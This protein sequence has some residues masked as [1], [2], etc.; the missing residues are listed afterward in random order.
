MDVRF[1]E[2]F[3]GL[4]LLVALPLTLVVAA[5]FGAMSGLRRWAAA[6]VR[7]AL[8]VAIVLL[9]VG[10][11]TVQKS[12]KVA[13]VAVV[14]LSSSVRRLGSA[15]SQRDYV[16]L[17]QQWLTQATAKRGAEDLVGV[18]AV[19]RTPFVI[20][21]VSGA[22]LASRDLDVEVAEG[23]NL[24]S[25]I[26]LARGMIP[27][28][29]VGRIVLLSDGNQTEGD[30]LAEVDALR[31]SGR[32][33]RG[34]IRLDVVPLRYQLDREVVVQ[35]IDAP[36][37]SA[38]ESVV[39][40]RVMLE[41]TAGA[42][43]QIVVQ[44]EGVLLDAN[45][46][47]PG[48]GAAAKLNPGT[49]IV[50]IQVKLPP[51]RVHRFQVTF[52]QDSAVAR[53]GAPAGDTLLENNSGEAFTLSPGKGQTLVLCGDLGPAVAP[54][55]SPLVQTL[56]RAG[57]EVRGMKPEEMPTDM[58]GVQAY[59]VVVLDNVPADRIPTEV[60]D[61]LVSFVTELGGGLVMVG[62]RD[63]FGA[64]GWRGTPIEPILPVSLELKDRLTEPDAAIVFVIDNSGSMRRNVLGS[65]RS[66]Q[67]IANDATALT[68]RSLDPRDLVGVVAFN[69]GPEEIV[70][71]RPNAQSE[72]SVELVRGIS[73]G[74]G[75]NLPPALRLAGERLAGVKAKVKQI[76]VLSDGRSDN[77]D[78]LPG[79]VE[80]LV[81][82]KVQ[83][84]CIAI[85]DE[86]DVKQLEKLAKLGLGAFYNAIDPES[87]PRLFLRAV[88]IVRKPAL[89][90]EPFVPV[91]V[92]SGSPMTNGL[93]QPLP[94][95]GGLVLTQARQDP[96]VTNAMVTA[97]GEPV[98]AHWQAGLGEVAAFTSDSGRWAEGWLAW[99]GYETMWSQVV[100]NVARKESSVGVTSTL[101]AVN[102]RLVA[103]ATILDGDGRPVT[104]AKVPA[105][106]YMPNGTTIE[107]T[108]ASVGPGRFER[109]IA[110]AMAGTAIVVVKPE[111][112]GRALSP[113]LA[114]VAVAGGRELTSLRSDDRLLALAAERGGGS[115]FEVE[116]VEPL[117]LFDRSGQLPRESL[118]TLAP[119]LF[120]SVIGLL[121]LDI[122]MRRVAWDRAFGS[123]AVR[124]AAVGVSGSM[125]SSTGL[126][127]AAVS[128]LRGG[129]EPSSA[130]A[131]VFDA[132]D[133]ERLAQAARDQRRSRRIAEGVP[134][135]TPSVAGESVSNGAPDVPKEQTQQETVDGES[136]LMAAKRRAR[137][138]MK[139]ATDEAL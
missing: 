57:L 30:L 43:G 70:P 120:V 66:Q 58:L 84:S 47:E 79:I 11:F 75:T 1:D 32:T 8:L 71:L 52:E 87:L 86:A 51:G 124:A 122:A 106:V 127:S 81:R 16:R 15:G 65:I 63:S 80:Q 23:S 17:A 72:K 21:P 33:E 14:D 45:G 110:P 35:A 98:L 100:R 36:S 105:T 104:D 117:N 5:G 19:G 6:A 37:S 9:A 55:A 38:A 90:E 126:A 121:L 48:M 77:D 123:R 93:T 114:G 25:G 31:A 64:G 118:K 107:T 18:V 128:R 89:R 44:R 92:R 82:E 29:A 103:G 40:L 10:V 76:V 7:C 2:P 113:V 119:A 97:A 138:Q 116:S 27:A 137:Q 12:N 67:E 62:G 78:E 61:R 99:G 13:V 74:G 95:L 54:D 41:S 108:L 115:L 69:A 94:A 83:V 136:S 28:D 39:T 22:S 73:S 88:R 102:G 129:S 59:D 132:K 60:Q 131:V 20:A 139:D 50:P 56:R 133:A 68:I 125:D 91:L 135:A 101:S 3:W 85:G 130:D 46:D 112:S 34:S 109:D 134:S 4:M 26:E 49:N 53:A 96:T 111:S 24:A 42:Q